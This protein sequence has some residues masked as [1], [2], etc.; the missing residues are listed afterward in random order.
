MKRN[1]FGYALLLGVLLS[2]LYSCMSDRTA[3]QRVLITPKLFDTAG[4]IYMQRYPCNPITIVHQSDTT[5]KHD[6]TIVNKV[7]TIGNYIHDTIIKT[8]HLYTKIHDRDTI[9]DGQQIT[10]LKSQIENKDKQ[11]AALNQ[12]VTDN[13][14]L[15]AQEHTRG[16]HWQLY[17]WILIAAIAAVVVLVILK[18][19]L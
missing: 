10:I 9:V 6:T 16:N 8:I 13:R 14:L 5:Y 19:K 15:A 4:Q 2:L 3:L 18:P 11:I 7:D 1:S 17:F 12:S